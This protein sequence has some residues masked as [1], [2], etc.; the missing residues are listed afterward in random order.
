MKRF[1]VSSVP[2][3]RTARTLG[4]C[5]ILNSVIHMANIAPPV[6][7]NPPPA[8]NPDP[9][10]PTT[11]HPQPPERPT[12]PPPQEPTRRR[13]RPDHASNVRIVARRSAAGATDHD[14]HHSTPADAASIPR[15]ARRPRTTAT[16]RAPSAQHHRAVKES[17]RRARV[18]QKFATRS[19]HHSSTRST[20]PAGPA[21]HARRS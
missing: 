6:S 19:Q 20:R 4:P 14:R 5:E 17:W 11:A 21:R 12:A 8:T 15:P 3:G 9:S 16:R 13:P 18:A 1:S 7:A 10:P 2:P